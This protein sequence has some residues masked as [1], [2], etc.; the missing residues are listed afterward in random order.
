MFTNDKR[1]NLLSQG[2]KYGSFYDDSKASLDIFA[3]LGLKR[4]Y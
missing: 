1:P 2:I 3:L 4:F